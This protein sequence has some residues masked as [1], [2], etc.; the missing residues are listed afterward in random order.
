M[1]R[2]ITEEARAIGIGRQ[3][4]AVEL[5]LLWGL[6]FTDRWIDMS[7]TRVSVLLLPQFNRLSKA[8]GAE[9]QAGQPRQATTL[10]SLH[11]YH[12][13]L[14]TIEIQHFFTI[15]TGIAMKRDVCKKKLL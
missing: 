4:E 12:T 2:L 10:L 3:L 6:E 5:E 15:G 1:N 14:Y 11:L 9:E 7:W 13:S 8:Q